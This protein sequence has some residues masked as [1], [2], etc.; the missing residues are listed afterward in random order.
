MIALAACARGEGTV[1]AQPAGENRSPKAV[2]AQEARKAGLATAARVKANELG[3]IPVLM[4]HRIVPKVT[5]ADDRTPQ[6]FRTELERLAREGYVP[7]TARE[8]ATGRIA[9]PAGRH[10]VVLTF[11]DSSPSQLTLDGSGAPMPDTAVGI[12]MD[13]A[14]KNPG[15]R[16][17]G[18][19]YV[20]KDMF[21]TFGQEAQAQTLG[22]LRD[23]GFDVGNH[24]RDHLNLRGRSK[25]QVAQQIAAGHT[26]IT[27]LIK[28]PPVTIAL[29]YGNQPTTKDWALRGAG[30]G[31]NYNYSGVF[32]AGYTPAASPFSKEFDPLGIPRIRAMDKV[33]DCARFC[34]TAWLD[35]LQA[36]PD[37][38]YTSDGDVKTVAYPKF[39]GPYVAPRFTRY[40]LA[41]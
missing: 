2:S 12:L 40:S 7:I 36:H 9:I 35:W 4:Y 20:I 34:S 15:F 1:V 23:H 19:F 6:Q 14:R 8:Y 29:P 25:E 24:T 39:K 5:A 21:G 31:V 13:V 28:D 41:Y 32:L 30:G 22:W 16:P 38:R 18:T 10:P 27:A 3:Q 11:D 26:L 17:V 37:D 33:G